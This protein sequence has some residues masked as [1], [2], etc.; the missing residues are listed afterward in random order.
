[1]TDNQEPTSLEPADFLTTVFGALPLPFR[2]GSLTAAQADAGGVVVLTAPWA[3]QIYLVAPARC[4][5]C[6]EQVLEQ[7]RDDLDS[8]ADP[9][10]AGPGRVLFERRTVGSPVV[11]GTGGGV[12]TGDVWIHPNFEQLGI[13]DGIRGVLAG[14]QP[15]L[16]VHFKKAFVVFTV[17]AATD[18]VR[19]IKI[20]SSFEEADA[21]LD[22]LSRLTPPVEAFLTSGPVQI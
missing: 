5:H 9:M 12:V 11:G 15:T 14:N 19:V 10:V 21:E 22:R 2:F 16:G 4:V 13:G 3:E 17:D 20:V 18:N 7:L 8:I 1:M 6:N